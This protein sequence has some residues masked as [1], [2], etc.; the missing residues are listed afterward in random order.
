M[1]DVSGLEY[2]LTSITR[3]FIIRTAM[4]I[5]RMHDPKFRS[6][7]PKDSRLWYSLNTFSRKIQI[8][9]KRS[10]SKLE[11]QEKILLR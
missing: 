7:K 1:F 9:S 8:Y 4:T 5:I 2:S 3:T 11:S 6:E 10:L